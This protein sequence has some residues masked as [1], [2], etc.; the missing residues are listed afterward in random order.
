[1]EKDIKIETE[2]INNTNQTIETM[3]NSKVKK[4]KN[5]KTKTKSKKDWCECGSGINKKVCCKYIEK[6]DKQR[7]AAKKR[8]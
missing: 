3:I 1:M 6:R 8:R 7:Q 2:K 4:D 5:N